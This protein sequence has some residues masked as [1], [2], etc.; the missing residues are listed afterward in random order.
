MKDLTLQTMIA[1]FEDM[2]GAWLFWIMVAAAVAITA[3]Y[4]YVLIRDRKVG[5]KK[6]LIA[7]VF[8]PIGAILA[9]A[10]VMVVT[11]SRMADI[12]G[13]IDV[14]IFL[15]IAGL[16]AVGMAILVYTVQSLLF[17][18]SPGE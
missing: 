10:F 18:P 2:F 13:P 8:M 6:F 15:G 4:L 3:L 14:I 17:R 11:H 16:G 9:V 1:V 5:W 12:G 7:Q